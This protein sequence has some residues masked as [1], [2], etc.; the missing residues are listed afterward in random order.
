MWPDAI[1]RISGDVTEFLAAESGD[2]LMRFSNILLLGHDWK[3]D[4]ML[5]VAILQRIGE[6]KRP[7]IG[8]ISSKAKWQSFKSVALSNGISEKTLDS[9]ICPIGVNIGAE[10]PQEI[11]IAVLAEI[12]AE[13]K[14][15]TACEASWRD[16]L[17]K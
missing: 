4:E 7:R 5:L 16:D 11:A 2:S 15:V 14:G 6:E 12:I 8:V 13:Q 17:A 9:V 3:V 10:T 1:E